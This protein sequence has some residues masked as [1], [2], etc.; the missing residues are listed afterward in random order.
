M[1]SPSRTSQQNLFQWTWCPREGRIVILSAA[2]SWKH[3]LIGLSD[4]GSMS[5]SIIASRGR[6]QELTKV[7]TFWCWRR[8]VVEEVCKWHKGA[9]T[10]RE[11][12]AQRVLK[13]CKTSRLCAVNKFTN[14]GSFRMPCE[15]HV[16]P[17][18]FTLNVNPNVFRSTGSLQAPL[19]SLLF[20]NLNLRTEML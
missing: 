5:I 9:C 1:C 7:R 4:L 11:I 20:Q 15:P 16:S 2:A 18:I 17:D 3:P 19:S 10:R 14:L 8:P 13:V 6:S 12:L